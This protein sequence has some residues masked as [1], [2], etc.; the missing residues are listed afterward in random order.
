MTTTHLTLSRTCA[1][2]AAAEGHVIH[3]F[4]EYDLVEGTCEREG[5][6]RERK[7]VRNE[8]R[9]AADHIKCERK[10]GSFADPS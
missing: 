3:A 7:T 1:T 10:L 2:H 5:E 8:G 6:M 9:S 4:G